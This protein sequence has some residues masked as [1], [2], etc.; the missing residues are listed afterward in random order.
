MKTWLLLLT[1]FT[2]LEAASDANQPFAGRLCFTGALCRD[3]ACGDRVESD[4]HQSRPFTVSTT[5]DPTYHLGVLNAGESTIPCAGYGTLELRLSPRKLRQRCDLR[6]RVADHQSGLWEL[7]VP[8]RQLASVITVKLPRGTYDVSIEGLRSVRVRKS[9]VI[10][11]IPA[12]VTVDLEPLP[13]LSGTVLAR[14]TGLPVAGAL[15]NTDIQSND[16]DKSAITDA[17]GRFAIDADPDQWPTKVL[18]RAIPYSA[19]STHVPAARVSTILSE[20]YV[21]RGGAVSIEVEQQDPVQVV[22]LELQP[23]VR[24]KATGKAA[25]TLT[26]P[27][28]L[29]TA[30]VR[31]ENVEPGQ[32]V[33]LAKGNEALERHGTGVTVV[34]GEEVMV[35]LAITPF[36]LRVLTKMEGE[37][38]PEAEIL[39][40]NLQ[41]NW[42]GPITTDSAGEA[43]V[44]LWQGGK[45]KS[46]VHSAAFSAPH[47]ERRTLP[48]AEDSEWILDIPAREIAGTVVD[49]KTEE[50]I[51]KAMLSL[52]IDG[53]DHYSLGV[54]TTADANG[55]FRFSPVPYG[56]HRLRT[57]AANYS[58]SE[59]SYLFLEPEADRNIT[60]RL[61]RATTVLIT[62]LDHV[63]APIAGARVIQ[64]NGGIRMQSQTDSFGRLGVPV[65]EGRAAEVY[66]I[67][68]D[69]SFGMATLKS[70]DKETVIRIADGAGRIVVRTETEEHVPIPNI[71]VLIRYNGRILPVDVLDGLASS[72][73]GSA[74]SD[75]EGRLI[76]ARMPAGLYEF[77]PAASAAELRTLEAGITSEA[78][79]KMIVAGGENVAVMTFERIVKR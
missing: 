17:A 22:E 2:M 41:G 73:G 67:P 28:S 19:T 66:V 39:L 68:P 6:L 48:D 31:F 24:N 61:E 46:A 71:S 12:R 62:V 11:D 49:S 64:L 78:R 56:K 63:G 52:H 15:V 32:Y 3:Y 35:H 37:A 53:Q 34:Q 30:T 50:P 36:T 21:S 69:G 29:Q 75:S 4:A 10:A 58:P 40:T 76:F 72:H 1:C 44:N 18:V 16:V 59:M 43:N 38:L 51:P 74:R 33:V 8:S 13:R 47:I 25:S 54:K 79:V 27:S 57:A 77:W 9:V 20:I 45:V 42:D 7:T 70:D 5:A 26:V 65:P 23:I 14:A 60:V 55:R